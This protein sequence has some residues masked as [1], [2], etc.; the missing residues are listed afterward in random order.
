M[1]MTSND[2]D[3]VSLPQ[4][5]YDSVVAD[6]VQYVY[7]GSVASARAYSRARLAL[8]DGLGCAV[9]TAAL[10]AECQ[11]LLGPVLPGTEVPGGCRVPGTSHIVDPVK[12]AF[13]IGALVRYLDHN[14]A[15]PGAEWGHPS[16]NL[17]AII[18]VADWRSQIQKCVELLTLDPA[19]SCH[20][21][22]AA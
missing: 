3:N 17:G 10:S 15:Y 16:D 22:T 6:I 21:D 18:A 5:R 12:G 2:H 4:A 8:L 14:D 13:D 9:E 11:S 1:N 7:H 19:K 20:S